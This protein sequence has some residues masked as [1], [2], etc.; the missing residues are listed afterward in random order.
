VESKSF[1]ITQG[2]PL[3]PR[4]LFSRLVNIYKLIILDIRHIVETCHIS[5][6]PGVVNVGDLPAV[7]TL[8]PASSFP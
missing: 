8:A 4:L 3:I 6:D 1:Y 2:L 5:L 7:P